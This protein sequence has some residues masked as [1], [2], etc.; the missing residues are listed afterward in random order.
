VHPKKQATGTV[1]G[2]ENRALRQTSETLS[3]RIF[4]LPDRLP[5]SQ[6][7]LHNRLDPTRVVTHYKTRVGTSVA[8]TPQ[9]Y[10]KAGLDA[11]RISAVRETPR[12]NTTANRLD[13]EDRAV[14]DWY[15]FVLSFPPHLVRDYLER[16]DLGPE[17]RVLDPFCGTGTTLVECKKCGVQSVGVEAN[18][19]AH[20]ASQVKLD[21]S[22][23]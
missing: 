9:S 8:G 10:G 2:L 18:P 6:E 3:G 5:E 21:W 14:H 13:V 7:V 20:F 4:S 23:L 16:F 22:P 1:A 17:H 11:M 12:S 19:M 15:R